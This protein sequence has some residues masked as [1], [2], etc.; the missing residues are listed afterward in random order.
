MQEEDNV[1]QAGFVMLTIHIA[2]Q[3]AAYLITIHVA[4]TLQLCDA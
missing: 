3:L 1:Q 2:M 4:K